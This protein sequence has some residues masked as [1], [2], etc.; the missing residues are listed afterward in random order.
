MHL[1]KDETGQAVSHS[2]GEDHG[3]EHT[4][5]HSGDH[6]HEHTHSHGCSGCSS[7]ECGGNCKDETE[8][9][10]TYMVQHN[11]QHAKELDQM[12][13]NLRKMGMEDAAKTIEEGVADFQKG[14]MRLSLA[15]TLVKEQ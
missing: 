11:L 9:L 13:A 1:I 14:N 3:H 15:L 2:H 5:S 6:D 12:A 4:H 10:L 8:A 7:A